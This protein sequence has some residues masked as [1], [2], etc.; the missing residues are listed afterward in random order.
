ML[1]SHRVI[2]KLHNA[3]TS[4]SLCE[5]R[6]A[7]MDTNWLEDFISFA[8]TMN[9]TKAASERH[10]TQSAFSRRIQSLEIWVGAELI[11]RK[12]FPA[13][14]TP[15]GEEFLPIAKN[16]IG[17][18]YRS[19][20]DIR[21]RTSDGLDTVRFAAPHS[22]SIHNLMPL[23]SELESA[24]PDLKTQV[25]SDNLHNC[26][27]QLSEQ[28]CDFLVCYQFSG[29]PM[30]LDAQKFVKIKIG[31]DR[32]VPVLSKSLAVTSKW[33]LSGVTDA[34]MPYLKYASGSYLGSVTDQIIGTRSPPLSVRHIDVFSEAIKSLC[35][36]GAGLAWLPEASIR[37]ELDNGELIIVGGTDWS[38]DL[39]LVVYT[40]PATHNFNLGIAWTFFSELGR[41][42][43]QQGA[44]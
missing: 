25:I 6:N 13:T 32:L 19:R 8:R 20:D 40:E 12:T 44:E 26:C 17:A 29:V 43:Y 11:D 14:L 38:A 4:V 30:T 16:M 5:E 21:A 37:S 28:N 27:D 34:P 1:C 41:A 18:L 2:P 15:A 23:L 33:S 24:I 36:Q 39:Q 31:R 42:T 3:S 7:K 10:I 22:I 9:F 35:L